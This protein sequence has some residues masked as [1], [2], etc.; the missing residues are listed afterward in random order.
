MWRNRRILSDERTG[1]QP[2]A[3]RNLLKQTIGA[4]L[5][6]AGALQI[7]KEYYE[8]PDQILLLSV[9]FTI[10]L[11]GL[12]IKNRDHH[13][14]YNSYF[15]LSVLPIIAVG[16][17]CYFILK[18]VFFDL[19]AILVHIQLGFDAPDVVHSYILDAFN[20]AAGVL[21]FIVGNALLVRTNSIYRVVERTVSVCFFAV[22][23]FWAASNSNLLAKSGNVKLADHYRE[24]TVLSPV[25]PDLKNF[26]HVYLESTEATYFD[27]HFGDAMAP[28]KPLVSRGL[29]ATNMVQ[30]RDT[31]WSA[32]G[33]AAANCGVPLSPIG[34]VR[35]N[36]FDRI[37]EFLP[38]A[39]CLGDILSDFG[40]QLSFVVGASSKFAGADHLYGNHG[41]DDVLDLAYFKRMYRDDPAA[42][43]RSKQEWGLQD[44]I[45]FDAALE[46]LRANNRNAAPFGLVIETIGGHAPGGYLSPRCFNQTD[47]MSI[48]TGVLR[49]V[50]CSNWLLAQF[51][52]VAERDGLLDD[53]I[54]VVQSDHLSMRNSIYR[55]LTDRRR[56]NLF[57]LFGES[58]KARSHD[59]PVSPLDVYPTIMEAIGVHLQDSRAGLG[60]SM[61]SGEKA[62]VDVYG[63]ASF[64]D[65]IRFDRDLKNMLWKQPRTNAVGNAAPIANTH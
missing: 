39:V 3:N 2:N 38:S 35:F 18:F 5:V 62:W 26:I 53:T 20:I 10:A 37:D 46:V 43:A 28:L 57:F 13:K 31:G 12:F 30:I 61:F 55:E 19:S 42:L 6:S 65:M 7:L 17:Y 36:N 11:Y 16:I 25:S 44:D 14:P 21:M 23:T 47:I 49:A 9:L 34:L 63:E 48:E 60:V 64:N 27:E 50:K 40:Y 4:L 24:P 8:L 51:L 32:A 1:L 52:A 15:Q 33:I 22:I 45:V 54:V 59:H 56:R 58:I 29:N 41:F